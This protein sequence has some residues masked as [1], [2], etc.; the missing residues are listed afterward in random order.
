MRATNEEPKPGVLIVEDDR[1]T[2]IY[3]ATLLGR[4]YRVVLASNGPEARQQLATHRGEISLILMD[5]SLR[6]GEDGISLTRFVREHEAW[7]EIPIIVT[8]A[9]AFPKDEQAALRAGCDAFL[10]K[11]YEGR[12][13][14]ACME[15]LLGPKS[16]T[17]RPFS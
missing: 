2:Q 11:P 13:L 15:A 9:H 16:E 1:E 5:L 3:M 7:R 12:K 6:G 10:A 4:S 14:I 8:T 17:R